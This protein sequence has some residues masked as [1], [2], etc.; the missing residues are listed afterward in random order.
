MVA[1]PTDIHNKIA[2]GAVLV[3]T[4]L[5]AIDADARAEVPELLHALRLSGCRALILAD[6]FKTF[7]YIIILLEI[8]PELE[9]G[10]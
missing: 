2:L 3:N 9:H 1:N 6:R 4:G 5:S 8:A 7:N 10:V